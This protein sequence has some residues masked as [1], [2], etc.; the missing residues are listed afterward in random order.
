MGRKGRSPSVGHQVRVRWPDPFKGPPRARETISPKALG[1][2]E[3]PVHV[4]PC[5]S[6]REPRQQRST[7]PMSHLLGPHSSDCPRRPRVEAM[8]KGEDCEPFYPRHLR[9]EHV[10]MEPCFSPS[11]RC[12]QGVVVTVTRVADEPRRAGERLL[13]RY[14]Q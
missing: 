10:C 1:H 5:T 11:F 2:T 12:V 13:C 14:H 3:H 7:S 8:S 9:C 6:G 4:G